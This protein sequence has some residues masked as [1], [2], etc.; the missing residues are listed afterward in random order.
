MSNRVPTGTDHGTGWI[1]T[2]HGAPGSLPQ[3]CLLRK[4]PDFSRNRIKAAVF[5]QEFWSHQVSNQRQTQGSRSGSKELDEAAQYIEKRFKKFGL[6]LPVTAE[7]IF[8]VSKSRWEPGCV[9]TT[10]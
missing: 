9:R 3:H 4:S 5:F 7:P 6:K 2:S 10:P 8:N 1:A